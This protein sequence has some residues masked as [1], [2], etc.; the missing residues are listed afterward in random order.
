MKTIVTHTSPDWDAITSVW[1]IKR[2]LPGFEGASVQFVPAGE[3]LKGTNPKEL[4]QPIEKIGDNEII[5]VDTGL[6]PLDHHQTSSTSE[7]GASRSWEYVKK[8]SANCSMLK[9]RR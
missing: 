3:H 5:H 6:G 4:D 2:Y 8:E 9:W 1:V 7:C